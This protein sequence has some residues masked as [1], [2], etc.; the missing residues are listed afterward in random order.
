MSP[1]FTATDLNALRGVRTPEQGAA[2][3]IRLATR[4]DEGPTGAFFD[5]AGVVPW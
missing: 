5:D 4:P 3:A 1:G 2:I